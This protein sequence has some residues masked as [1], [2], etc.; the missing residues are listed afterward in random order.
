MFDQYLA[1]I[2]SEAIAA[3][4]NEAVWLITE[5]GCRNVPNKSESPG[6]S[7]RVDPRTMAAARKKG[8]LAVVHSHPDG[9]H[10]PSEAD[11]ISQVNEDVPWGLVECTAEW[12]SD[13]VWWGDEVDIPPLVGR[14]FRHGITD[15]YSLIRDYFRSEKGVT[16]PEF[17][18]DW[19]WWEKGGD[20]FQ[21]G[22]EKAG[23][24]RI[25]QEEAQPGDVWLAQIHSPKPNHGG[26][27]LEGGLCIHQLGSLRP[28]D[29]SKLSVREP[30][31]R[32]KNF[33][34]HWLRYVG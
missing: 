24:I 12:C 6:D 29:T 20:L 18:R 11:M 5:D 15:C 3:Y 7:F 22:F 23:F 19:L 9:P 32:F 2:K 25:S 34:T 16:L 31:Y 14:T 30:V 13:L 21:Q 8:L 4:P 27:L 26:V 10:A 17:P 1:Q 28:V 33:I